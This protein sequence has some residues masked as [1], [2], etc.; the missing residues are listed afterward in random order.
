MFKFCKLLAYDTMC[1]II[2]HLGSQN[3]CLMH[4]TKLW[5]LHNK[6]QK[7]ELKFTLAGGNRIIALINLV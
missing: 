4:Q 7:F 6:K 1:N 2:N 3:T 5:E